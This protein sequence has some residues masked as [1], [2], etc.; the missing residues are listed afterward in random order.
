MHTDR[1]EARDEHERLRRCDSEGAAEQQEGAAGFGEYASDVAG[2][3]PDPV[4]DG[5][6]SVAPV[7]EAGERQTR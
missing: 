2:V 3:W 5:A 7:P 4:H 1:F 6:E